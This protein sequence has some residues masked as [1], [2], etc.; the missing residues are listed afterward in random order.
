MI[1]RV[2]QYLV[3]SPLTGL[4]ALS[5]PAYAYLASATYFVP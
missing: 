3:P 5:I 1:W 4:L 2:L